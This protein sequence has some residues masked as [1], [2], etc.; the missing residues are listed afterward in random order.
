MRCPRCGGW[1]KTVV[2]VPARCPACG[3][4]VKIIPSFSDVKEFWSQFFHGRGLAFWTFI[5]LIAYTI[6]G[7]LE[8]SFG[9]GIMIDYMLRHWFISLVMATFLGSVLDLVA[10]TNVEIR[11][12][13]STIT[14]RLPR[15][16]RFWRRGTN[17]SLI[18]GIILALLIM[19][20]RGLYEYPPAF[21]F[22]FVFFLCCFWAGYAFL[23]TDHYA[24]DI[25][26]RA[27]FK[28]LG[29]DYLDFLRR[30]AMYYIVG[31]LAAVIVFL[32]LNS[33]KG[34]W[35][36]VSSHPLYLLGCQIVI[37]A[38]KLLSGKPV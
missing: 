25:K 30:I 24:R 1:M 22:L 34:L 4:V 32:T 11:E 35:W 7:M 5:A 6:V 3:K 8:V 28:R 31:A 36:W 15:P 38:D 13:A 27:F 9:D 14:G 17:F 23:L 2:F 26:V 18:G 20:P 33:I 29:I 10:R 37:W 19:S 21:K 12:L 16:L